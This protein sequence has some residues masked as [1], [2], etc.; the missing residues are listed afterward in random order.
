[1]SCSGDG[2]GYVTIE[3]DKVVSYTGAPEDPEIHKFCNDE[4]VQGMKLLEL[5]KK[6]IKEITELLDSHE[7]IDWARDPSLGKLDNKLEMYK[8]LLEESKK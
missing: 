2:F 1:M 3:D 5:T 4:F 6:R 7:D 8:S